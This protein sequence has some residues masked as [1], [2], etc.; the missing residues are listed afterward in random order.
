MVLGNALIDRGQ[1]VRIAPLPEPLHISAF[2]R[3]VCKALIFA[4]FLFRCDER[5][6]GVIGAFAF[7]YSLQIAV[8][9]IQCQFGFAIKKVAQCGQWQEPGVYSALGDVGDDVRHDQV[10]LLGLHAGQ[11]KIVQ[12]V[13]VIRFGLDVFQIVRH[14]FLVV[15]LKSLVQFPEQAIRRRVRRVDFGGALGLANGFAKIGVRGQAGR[16]PLRV[17]QPQA[18]VRFCQISI[19]LFGFLKRRTRRVKIP[20][21]QIRIAQA[22]PD[23][24]IIGKV[25]HELGERRNR[26]VCPPLCEPRLPNAQQGIP[27]IRRRLMPTC[28]TEQ[29]GENTEPSH[30]KTPIK[31]NHR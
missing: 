26:R 22:R 20:L 28:K 5:D 21:F 13:W 14:G 29:C 16:R 11:P 31:S 15:F 23:L 9:I 18:H 30:R 27:L 6:V 8:E 25:L 7:L 10:V 12:P 4:P 2:F 17:H 3:R 19:P 1:D 24:G